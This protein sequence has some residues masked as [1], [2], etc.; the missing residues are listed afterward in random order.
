MGPSLLPGSSSQ[1][2]IPKWDMWK[3]TSRP[4]SGLSTWSNHSPHQHTLNRQFRKWKVPCEWLTLSEPLVLTSFLVSVTS[5]LYCPS[6]PCQF[7]QICQWL[8]PSL[9]IRLKEVFLL[10]NKLKKQFP[11]TSDGSAGCL[12]GSWGFL[13]Q[14]NGPIGYWGSF[15]I[16]HR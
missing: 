10:R 6:C 12:R 4:N 1:I 7:A 15:I 9:E 13:Q 3:T 16:A 5:F 14:L 11:Q 2:C 8:F